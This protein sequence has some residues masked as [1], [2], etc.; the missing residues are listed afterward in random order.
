MKRPNKQLKRY[1]ATAATRAA[2]L[3][4]IL[5]YVV[6]VQSVVKEVPKQMARQDELETTKLL[7]QDDGISVF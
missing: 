7:I 3:L 4:A 2:A 5:F 6:N 1:R